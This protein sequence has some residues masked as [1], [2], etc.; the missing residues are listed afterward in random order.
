MVFVTAI[1]EDKYE[2]LFKHCLPSQESFP[3][4]PSTLGLDA[5]VYLRLLEAVKYFSLSGLKLYPAT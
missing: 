2:G 1:S 4:A 5:P 3:D